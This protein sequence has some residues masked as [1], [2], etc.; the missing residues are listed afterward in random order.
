MNPGSLWGRGPGSQ[1]SQEWSQ[2]ITGQ[3]AGRRPPCV[4][5]TREGGLTGAAAAAGKAASWA[6]SLT[7]RAAFAQLGPSWHP[8]LGPS[9]GPKLLA[10]LS[11]LVPGIP[12]G[13]RGAQE[14][15]WVSEE[16]PGQL[17]LQVDLGCFYASPIEP[18]LD[19]CCCVRNQL[20]TLKTTGPGRP[21]SSFRV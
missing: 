18:H 16:V 14:R 5:H 15:V 1:S 2:V 7:R 8:P 20:K 3:I 12:M 21:V 4:H 10:G 11:A 17:P 6:S 13:D 9:V 19:Q